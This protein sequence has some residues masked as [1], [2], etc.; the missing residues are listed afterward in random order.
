MLAK[1]GQ[2]MSKA[3]ERA[4][5]IDI[6]GTE[7]VIVMQLLRD[8]RTERWTVAELAHEI[9]DIGPVLL[10]RALG[11]LEQEQVVQRAGSEIWASRAVRRLDELRLIG[12]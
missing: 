6:W 7:R 2:T 11:R 9:G 8:D 3:A 5:R 1:G 4:E 12:I 10:D